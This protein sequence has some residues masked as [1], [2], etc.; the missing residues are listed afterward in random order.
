MTDVRFSQSPLIESE[1]SLAN[2]PAI[3]I[4]LQRIG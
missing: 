4:S 2:H 3:P 1:Q